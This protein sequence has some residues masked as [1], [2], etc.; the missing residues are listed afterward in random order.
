V[1]AARAV[2]AACGSLLQAAEET[3][4]G[5]RTLECWQAQGRNKFDRAPFASLALEVYR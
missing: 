5:R 1:N 2:L 4:V 3:G